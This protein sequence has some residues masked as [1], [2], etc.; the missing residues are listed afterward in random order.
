MLQCEVLDRVRRVGYQL[1]LLLLS[2]ELLALEN[3]LQHFRAKHLASREVE[4]VVH[5]LQLESLQ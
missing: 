3:C 1:L 4:R 2:S 5:Q